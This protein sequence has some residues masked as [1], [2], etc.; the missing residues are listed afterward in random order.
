GRADRKK[1]RGQRQRRCGALRLQGACGKR[2]CRFLRRKSRGKRS[3]CEA[4]FPLCVA[5]AARRAP[6]RFRPSCQRSPG[7]RLCRQKRGK[8]SFAKFP[9]NRQCRN[10]RGLGVGPQGGTWRASEWCAEYGGDV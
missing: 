5:L 3:V 10:G 8:A 6:E 1:A 9:W 7:R 4:V 2:R